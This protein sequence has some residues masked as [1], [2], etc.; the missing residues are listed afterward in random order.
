MFP[1][2]VLDCHFCKPGN[3]VL[4]KVIVSPKQRFLDFEFPFRW[5]TTS[6]E[7][8][9]Q[10]SFVTS[11]SRARLRLPMMTSYSAWLFDVLN[12]NFKACSRRMPL[13][14]LS[15]T[16]APHDLLLEDP[17]TCKIHWE[18]SPSVER[19][20]SLVAKSAKACDLIA[21]LGWYR[22]WNSDNLMTQP[23]TRSTKSGFGYIIIIK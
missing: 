4:N 11:R 18:L 21:P 10:I 13:G 19:G 12:S 22:I 1:A 5:P 14:P 16:P 17:S 9:L 2:E 23:I 8:L 6:W 15:T 3:Q 20:L 7:S